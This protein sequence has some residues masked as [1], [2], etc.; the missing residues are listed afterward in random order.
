MMPGL[1]VTEPIDRVVLRLAENGVA[2]KGT[3]IRDATGN[4]AHI[5]DPD[6]HEIY[7]WGG[8]SQRR[9]RLR[10]HPSGDRI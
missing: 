10:F 3:I 4:F 1:E 7:L 5:E 8:G 6:G 2:I 9:S